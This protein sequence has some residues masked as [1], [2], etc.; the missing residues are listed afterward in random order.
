QFKKEY[1]P[2]FQENDFLMHWVAKPGTSID[3]MREDII[4][5]SKQMRWEPK[6]GAMVD[7]ARDDIEKIRDQVQP[8]S[9]THVK[10]FGSHIARA[11]VGEEVVGPN[12]AELWISL[13]NYDGDQAAARREIER[14]M[15]KHPGF[16]YD[17]LTY[18]K[19]R[20]KEVLSGTGSTVVLRIYGPELD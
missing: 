14:V 2:E 18:L 19:E 4:T 6:P 15:A 8:N 16:Q 20:I 3:F 10:D 13:G 11:E 1:L 9:R 5:V 12:F 17:L 7:L